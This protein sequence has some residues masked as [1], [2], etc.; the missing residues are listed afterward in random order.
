ME[1]YRDERWFCNVTTKRRY[2]F[3]PFRWETELWCY[4]NPKW[5]ARGGPPT[6]TLGKLFYRSDLKA[7]SILA[8]HNWITE[9]L[10][11]LGDSGVELSRSIAM[12]F[13][14]LSAQHVIARIVIAPSSEDH[15]PSHNFSQI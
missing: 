14:E 3:L 13:G 1:L 8:V 12:V 4:V 11:R 5:F 10:G 15:T 7:S 9:R 2:P 6:V